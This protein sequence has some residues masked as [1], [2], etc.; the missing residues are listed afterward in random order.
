MIRDA[1]RIEDVSCRERNEM[2]K[3]KEREFNDI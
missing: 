1:Y 3:V 2:L